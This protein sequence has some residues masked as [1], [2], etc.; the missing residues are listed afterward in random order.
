MEHMVIKGG[1]SAAV[2]LVF[3]PPNRAGTQQ[4]ALTIYS[5]DP[6]NPVQRIRVQ[7]LMAD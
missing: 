4:K 7:A 5:N 2:R 1:D 6:R 3:K